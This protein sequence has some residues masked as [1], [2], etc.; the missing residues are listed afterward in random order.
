MPEQQKSGQFS[1]LT[2]IAIIL[3]SL[4]E[5][6]AVKIMQSLSPETIAALGKELKKLPPVSVEEQSRILEEFTDVIPSSGAVQGGDEVAQKLLEGAFGKDKASE[7]LENDT[8]FAFLQEKDDNYI[9]QLL[10]EESPSV[11]AI[12]LAYLS[13]EKAGRVIE[14]LEDEKQSEVISYLI[15]KRRTEPGA[16]QRIEKVIVKKIGS[17]SNKQI[18]AEQSDIGG[19][20]FIAEICQ[21]AGNETEEKILSKIEEK[22]KESAEEVRDLL[23]TFEDIARLE[24]A[25]LQLVLREVNADE[26]ATALKQASSE[27]EE[28]IM[29]NISKSAKANLEEERELMGKVK[30]SQV[31]EAQHKIVSVVRELESKEEISFKKEGEE[32]DVYI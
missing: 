31:H 20:S 14:H 11:A 10:N 27:V 30:L 23:F 29:G 4:E 12:V 13:P 15:Q 9:G 1:K 17:S 26:L 6:D 18:S 3:Q 19:T 28:K 22:S 24:D 21:N 32:E 8:P 25:D 16:L 7:L 2:K 5:E